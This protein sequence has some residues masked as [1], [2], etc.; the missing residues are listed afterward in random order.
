MSVWFTSDLHIGHVKV[1]EH[2]VPSGGVQEHDAILA[3]MWDARVQPDDQVWV[4][5]DISS[6]TKS[7]QLTALGWLRD[8]PG[9]KHLIAGNHDGVHPLHRDSH[10]WVRPYVLGAFESVQLAAKRRIP[11]AQGHVTAMLSHFPYTGDH[12]DEDRYPEWRL[13]D[14]G[15]YVLHGHTHSADHVS[16]GGAPSRNP[17]PINQIHVGVDAWGFRPVHL[18]EIVEMVQAIEEARARWA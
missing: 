5:G 15:H 4:L 3:T 9:H 6:G 12:K 10:K 18:D 13:P 17:V 11:L 7:G 16:V 8:R 2:R 1:A 14:C